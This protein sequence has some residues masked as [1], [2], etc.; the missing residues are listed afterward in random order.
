MA[1]T[2]GGPGGVAPVTSW[3]HGIA[4]GAGWV[5]ESR[6]DPEDRYVVLVDP[7]GNAFCVC[8]VASP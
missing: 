7:E 3:R 1:R 2:L 5:R 8:E 6:E 4:R